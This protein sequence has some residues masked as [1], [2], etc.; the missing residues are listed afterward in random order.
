MNKQYYIYILT[1]QYN[2]VVYTGV[3]SNLKKRIYE[4][5]KK[6]IAGFTN[7]YNIDKLVYYEIFSD[8]YQ[9]ISREKQI[10]SG[11]RRKKLNLINDM[12]PSWKDL[13]Y[14]L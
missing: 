7:K 12:N 8:S 14:D 2:K 11:S 10:K 6:L 4:H 5:K 3:T 9:A 1:N 13:Y